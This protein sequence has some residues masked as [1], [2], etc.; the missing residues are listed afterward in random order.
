M[1]CL[2]AVLVHAVILIAASAA[3]AGQHVDASGFSV[4]FPDNWTAITRP[5]P[6]LS[7]AAQKYLQNNKV[8]FS[9]INIP[10]FITGSDLSQIHTMGSVRG[11]MELASEKK[12]I[13]WCGHQE[14]FE[15]YGVKESYPELKVCHQKT[16]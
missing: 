6:E 7:V 2:Q 11:W 1:R 9:K 10:A 8:D 15:L 16:I 12:W 5:G 14:W 4:K 13:K 3:R